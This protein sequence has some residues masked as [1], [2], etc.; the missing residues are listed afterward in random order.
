MTTLTKE[1][2]AICA[3]AGITPSQLLA[4]GFTALQLLAAGC[5]ALQL[6]AAG[7]TAS[8]LFNDETPL[9]HKPYTALL[10]AINASERKFDQSS[11]GPEISPPAEHICGTAMCTAGHLVSMAGAQGQA[12][13]EK[14]GFPQAA[15]LIHAKAHPDYPCQNFGIIPDAWALAYIEMMAGVE[16]KADTQ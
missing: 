2:M 10:A 3:T 14:L 8:Q 4:A 9:L 1:Q 5:T 15:A 12:L 6:L 13:K 11:F 16:A 7:C